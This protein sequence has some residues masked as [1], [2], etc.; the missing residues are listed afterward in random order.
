[1]P[2]FRNGSKGGIAANVG[3]GFQQNITSLNNM[4]C[5]K[6]ESVNKNLNE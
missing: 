2:K 6:K 3:P 1:M 4:Q 5:N